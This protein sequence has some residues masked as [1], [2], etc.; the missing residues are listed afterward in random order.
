MATQAYEVERATARR[1]MFSAVRWSAV[2]AGTVAGVATYLLLALLGIATGLT[3][4]DP[5]AAQP[6]G[7]VPFWTGLWSLLSMLVA[8]FVGGWVAGR[9]SGLRRSLD[10]MLHGFVAWGLTTLF[11][12]FLATST[13]ANMLGGALNVIGQAAQGGGGAAIQLQ[14]LITGSPGGA[15]VS[16]D[17]LAALRE[18]MTAQNR[19]GAVEVMVNRMGFSEQRA[20]QVADQLMPLFAQPEQAAAGLTAASW[21]LFFT[22]LIALVLGVWGGGLGTRGNADRIAHDHAA[23]RRHFVG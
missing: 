16:A 18:Q 2:F 10:G 17:D 15:D 13:A 8:A 23:E 3:A 7:S 12:A 20:N 4:I 19:T 1:P 21:W 9:M 22:L 5:G 14:Q 11:F 6:V